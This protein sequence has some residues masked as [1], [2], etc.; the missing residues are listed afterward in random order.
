M[1]INTETN[2]KACV[3]RA[4]VECLHADFSCPVLLLFLLPCPSPR[5]SQEDLVSR[6][7]SAS[8]IRC[9]PSLF[10]Y[11]AFLLFF[12]K[13]I[14]LPKVN[15][16]ASSLD[17]TFDLF[18]SLFPLAGFYFWGRVLTPLLP[19]ECWDHRHACFMHCCGWTWGLVHATQTLF[20]PSWIPRP[21]YNLWCT[22][23]TLPCPSHSVLWGIAYLSIFF[24]GQSGFV[25]V[26]E[27]Q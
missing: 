11:L 3:H 19:L 23:I 16:C 18:P 8:A 26:P 24:S 27:S 12:Q 22:V 7:H 25:R 1:H 4:H 10:L 6:F 9:T 17:V 21:Q 13:S 15:F 14:F 2:L 5:W 20:Q